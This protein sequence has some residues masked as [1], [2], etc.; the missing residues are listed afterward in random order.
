M[1]RSLAAKTKEKNMRNLK[2]LLLAG[3]VA[4]A[5][6]A[7]AGVASASATVL[8]C[9][10]GARCAE[11]TT[12]KAASESKAVLDT[13]VGNVECESTVEVTPENTIGE[14][15]HGPI[16]SLGFT[17]CGS[18]T[19]T[20]LANGSLSIAAI[21]GTSNG[22]LTS[23]GTR[24]TVVH[25]G[26]HCIYETSSTK[27]GTVTGSTSTGSNATFDV[28]A[29]VPR[30]GGTGGAFCG[31]SASWTGSYEV[32]SPNPLDVDSFTEL[33][34]FK[35]PPGFGIYTTE[36]DCT[37]GYPREPLVGEWKERLK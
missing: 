32:T 3:A 11:G 37:A 36:K 24:V 28:S 23:T 2:L 10:S 12:L 13:S 25:L 16:S 4:V 31:S 7:L 22:S 6:T 21:S 14:T 9:G 35:T 17:G 27:I 19:V 29:S 18:D 30:V 20:V 5:L 26:V 1:S 34:C 15:V 33:E 8:T